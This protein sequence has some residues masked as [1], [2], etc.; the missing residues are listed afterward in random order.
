MQILFLV[1]FDVKSIEASSLFLYATLTISLISIVIIVACCMA[2]LVGILA[3]VT[4][5]PTLILLAG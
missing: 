3:L 4:S 1:W 2:P 5:H